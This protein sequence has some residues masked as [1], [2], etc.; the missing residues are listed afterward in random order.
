[1]YF[2]LLFLLFFDSMYTNIYAPVIIDSSS[3]D[4]E[5]EEL[6]KENW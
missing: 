5:G 6:Q 1:M 4:A 2:N 3:S